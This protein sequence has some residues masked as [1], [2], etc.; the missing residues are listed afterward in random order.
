V[1]N[2][3][4]RS[5]MIRI[6]KKY[7]SGYQ[8]EKCEMSGACTTYGGVKMCIQEPGRKRPIKSTRRI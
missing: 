4:M 1:E 3:I 8:I 5:L 7:Y 2:Y 6:S